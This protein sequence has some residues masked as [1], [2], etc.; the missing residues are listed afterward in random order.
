MTLRITHV[1]E[2]SSLRATLRLEG[3]LVAEWAALLE[4]ECSGLLRTAA[5]V[6]LDLTGVGIVDRAGIEVL[7]RLGLAGVRIRCRPG[8]VAGVLEAE[9]VRVTRDAGGD[10]DERP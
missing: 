9:G 3:R 10:D 6:S 5:A 2:G 7:K 4:R 8:P 1:E